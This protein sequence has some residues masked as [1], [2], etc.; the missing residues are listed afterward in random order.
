L[1]RGREKWNRMAATNIA[2]SGIFSSDNTIMRYAD[3]I[4]G[5]DY[6]K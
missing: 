1:F 5:V 3:E 6:R 4:W 2:C